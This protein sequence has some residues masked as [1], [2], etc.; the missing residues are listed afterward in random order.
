MEEPSDREIA[1]ELTSIVV[2]PVVETLLLLDKATLLLFPPPAPPIVVVTVL[3]DIPAFP[4]DAAAAALPGVL[5]IRS[6]VSNM[7]IRQSGIVM[8]KLLQY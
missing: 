3:P 6:F 7:T 4:F 8:K 5:R 1:P 2:F